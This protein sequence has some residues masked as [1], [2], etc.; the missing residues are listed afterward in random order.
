MTRGSAGGAKLDDSAGCVY[1]FAASRDD[2]RPAETETNRKGSLTQALIRSRDG[3][4]PGFTLRITSVVGTLDD[5][6]KL[7][8]RP[9]LADLLVSL[10]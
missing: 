4:Y 3:Q 5:R 9:S 10:S 2:L 6:G 8:Y 1:A 7:V